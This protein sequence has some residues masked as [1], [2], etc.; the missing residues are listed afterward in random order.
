MT[1]S[2]ITLLQWTPKGIEKVKEE[3]YRLDPIRKAVKEGGGELKAYPFTLG[4]CEKI[5]MSQVP[6]GMMPLRP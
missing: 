1:P 2:S 4:E 5:S 3:P 6:R